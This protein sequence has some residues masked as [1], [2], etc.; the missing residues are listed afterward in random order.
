MAHFFRI[1]E[2]K[3]ATSP[4]L[5]A[6][7]R[8]ICTN[9]ELPG[10][11]PPPPHPHMDPYVWFLP[12]HPEVQPQFSKLY[13]PRIPQS[14][15]PPVLRAELQDFALPGT[16]FGRMNRDLKIPSH[17]GEVGR[18]V[19]FLLNLKKYGVGCGY[20]KADFMAQVVPLALKEQAEQWWLFHEGFRQWEPFRKKFLHAN[21]QKVMMREMNLRIQ[22]DDEYLSA[23]MFVINDYFKQALPEATDKENLEKVVNQA[24]PK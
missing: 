10:D 6:K 20:S 4:E 5:W 18:K 14:L 16:Q 1:T 8:R 11:V 24:H 19:E 17:K 13:P 23:F 3:E 21:Y 7:I 2:E 22:G 12:P 9:T 15:Q